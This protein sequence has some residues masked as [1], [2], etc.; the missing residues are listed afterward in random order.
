MDNG[1]MGRDNKIMV[2]GTCRLKFR[3]E[4]WGLGGED[5]DSGK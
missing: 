3:L 4:Y 2:R 1:I 5:L